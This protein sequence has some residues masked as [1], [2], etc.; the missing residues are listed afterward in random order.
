MVQVFGEC[1]PISASYIKFKQSQM[2]V[3]YITLNFL[4][5]SLCGNSICVTEFYYAND[6]RRDESLL[7]KFKIRFFI[8]LTRRWRVGVMNESV[9]LLSNKF[10]FK[11]MHLLL[12]NIIIVL[13][14]I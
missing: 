2:Y 11:M 3:N 8:D 4:D 9:N 6:D 12:Y 1:D 13:Y 14:S 7:I 5:H 10:N